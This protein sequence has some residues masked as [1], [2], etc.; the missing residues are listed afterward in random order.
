MNCK[1]CN[2]EIKQEV[3]SNLIEISEKVSQTGE[4]AFYWQEVNKSIFC[5]VSCLQNYI[6]KTE[7]T[8][9][10]IVGLFHERAVMMTSS[11]GDLW[12]I[13]KKD[14]NSIQA[15]VKDEQQTRKLQ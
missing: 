7:S 6:N 14:W 3:N 9:D 2:K 10:R 4:F 15:Q 1:H 11:N 8:L 13:D 12:Q 5:S